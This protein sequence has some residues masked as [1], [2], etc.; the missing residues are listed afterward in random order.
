MRVVVGRIF[1]LQPGHEATDL[2]VFKKAIDSVV[3]VREFFF[4]ENRVNFVMADAMHLDFFTATMAA[5]HEM[6]FVD[7]RA[8]H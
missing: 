6:M 2:V 8:D 1:V 3:I 5:G 7:R 4:C